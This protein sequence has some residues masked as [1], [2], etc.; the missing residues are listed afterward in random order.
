MSQFES[1]DE[2]VERR[3][4]FVFNPTPAVAASRSRN[5]YID[6]AVCQAD[7]SEYLF[8]KVGVRFVRCRT[9]GMVYVNPVCEA[10]VNYFDIDRALRWTSER[11]RALYLADFEV[12]LRRLE[13]E[14][15]RIEGRPPRRTLLLGRFSR[16][17]VNSQCARRIGLDL[18]EVSD[19]AFRRLV[20]SN[21]VDWARPRLSQ[22]ADIV[23]LHEMLEACSDPGAVVAGL[24]EGL[25]RGA[26]AVVTYSNAQS[27]PAILL[28]RYWSSFYDFKSSFFNTA[29]LTALLARHGF[30]LKLQFPFPVTHTVGYILARVAPSTRTSKALTHTPAARLA[31]PLRTGQHVA[32]FCRR[33]SPTPTKEKL[34][35]VMPVFNEASYVSRVIDA[36]LEKKLKVDKELVIVESN[37]S[38]GT[39]D[40]V[41]RYE[42][43]PEV[44]LV[45]EDRPRGK[46]HAVRT[47][48][49]AVTGTIV[50]IQ[51]ADFEYDIDDY[52]AL[53]EPILQR[54]TSFVLGSRSLGLDDWKV[55]RFARG[56]VKGL[57][58][59]LAQLVFARTFNA[60]YQK[61]TTDINTM[62][63]VFRTECLEGLHLESDGF[64]LDIELVCKL[65]RNG[66]DAMEVPVNYVAR[67]FD[68]GKK[69]SFVR[70]AVPS[71]MA[72]YKYRF[73]R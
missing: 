22:P 42:K 57:A 60:L 51:D 62:F 33:P 24:A 13:S 73:A 7:N 56:Q 30:G 34:S 26:W 5:R 28:R 20:M 48:L 1:R 54:K 37:S 32:I 15:Q 23:I 43:N 2:R 68:E 55:R 36:V 35:I 10:G 17:L 67:G 49:R 64:E 25:P 12:F 72:L 40:I 39:R 58:L 53:L 16:D 63:K 65:V 11:D 52:D 38:D 9:C 29:N 44:K 19:D 66:N 71:Y 47:G 59:N 46:G 41:R 61:R 70:D 69:I 18:V 50:L 27:F 8:H 3:G 21:D 31:L 45:F 14:F 6:C 4:G